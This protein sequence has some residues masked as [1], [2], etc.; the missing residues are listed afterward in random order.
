VRRILFLLGDVAQ[1]RNDNH[2]RLP[3][4]FR[5]IGWE[6]STLPCD[7]VRTH[8]G[9]VKFGTWDAA[10]FE[11]IWPL[12]FGAAE[13]FFDRMQLL[14]LLPP[15]RLVNGPRALTFLH[16]KYRWQEQMPETHAA[17]D[18]ETLARVVAQGGDWIIKPPAGSYGRDVTLVRAGE[19]PRPQLQRLILPT[20]DSQPRYC[21]V[22]RFVAAIAQGETRT[23][24]A[25][26]Q[27]VGSY[28]RIPSDGLHANLAAH[29]TVRPAQL[30]AG[31]RSL[32]TRL[33][34][35]L[36]ASGARFAAIDLVKNY[37]LEVNVANPGGL[38]TLEDLYQTHFSDRIAHCIVG[39]AS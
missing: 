11:L 39:D 17:N 13:S 23:L 38:S 1:A 32:V 28:L 24:V 22:Q 19:D 37:L 20:P 15:E 5:S 12:G 18:I 33:A 34:G 26:G 35:E 29:A 27:I 10:R 36:A 8:A 31:Q 2:E 16:G 14:D 25:G 3:Q 21:I 6:V 9:S 4:G 7:S 30:T